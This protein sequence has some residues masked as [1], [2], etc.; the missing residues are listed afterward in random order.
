MTPRAAERLSR[1]AAVQGFENAI[2]NVVKKYGPQTERDFLIRV[3]PKER[4]GGFGPYLM[5]LKNLRAASAMV[6]CGVSRKGKV[7]WGTPNQRVN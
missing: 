4:A 5:A 3:N 1:E 6:E 7:R 2:L